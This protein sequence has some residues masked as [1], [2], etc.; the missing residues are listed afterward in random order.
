M[1][2]DGRTKTRVFND[3]GP[4]FGKTEKQRHDAWLSEKN[5]YYCVVSP[6]NVVSTVNMSRLYEGNTMNKVDT[7][8][9]TVTLV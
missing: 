9:E 3:S 6:S 2:L 7:W 8:L 4:I 5:A 1:T